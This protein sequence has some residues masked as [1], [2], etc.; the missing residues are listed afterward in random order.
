MTEDTVD[1]LLFLALGWLLGLLGPVIVDA[2]KRK[3]ENTQGQAAIHAELKDVSHKL[4]LASQF[5]YMRKGTVD[6]N[7]LEWFKGHL[8][9]YSS[10]EDMASLLESVKLQLSWTDKELEGYA[11]RTSGQSGKGIALQ[12]Y[13]VPLL[14]SRVNALWSFSTTLQRHLLQIRTDI[15]LL[16]DIVE[17]SRHFSN[18]TFSKLEGNNHALVLENIDQCNDLYF[19]RAKRVVDQIQNLEVLL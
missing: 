18:M 13:A 17:R 9:G 14:D 19:E 11:R 3:R 12:K 8:E 10:L 1:K 7:H 16:N 5:I 4:A 6:R 2:I 15:G